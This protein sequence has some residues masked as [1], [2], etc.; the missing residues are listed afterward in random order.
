MSYCIRDVEGEG[1]KEGEWVLEESLEERE[2]GGRGEVPR[3]EVEESNSVV[4]GEVELEEKP[5]VAPFVPGSIIPAKSAA[6]KAMGGEWSK[7]VAGVLRG[8]RKLAAR[9][10]PQGEV[11][12][13]TRSA[14]IEIIEPEIKPGAPAPMVP[15]SAATRAVTGIWF[16][17]ATGLLEGLR[18]LTQSSEPATRG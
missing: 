17:N 14:D 8:M 11:S 6:V 13:D 16:E 15:T 3:A 4:F 5:G 10:V 7:K 9:A 2:M 12:K 18:K 1:G